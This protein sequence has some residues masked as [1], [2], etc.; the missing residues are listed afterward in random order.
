[1]AEII[2]PGIQ[3]PTFDKAA[4]PGKTY[5]ALC[6]FRRKVLDKAY[7]FHEETH[8][9]VDELLAGRK[10]EDMKCMQVRDVFRAVGTWRKRFNNDKTRVN[11]TI[12]GPGGGTGVRSNSISSIADLNKRN[13]ERYK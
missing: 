2:S 12:S 8:D 10:L 1:M 6:S 11:D 3:V 7:Q 9:Y 4:K 13:A 5:D